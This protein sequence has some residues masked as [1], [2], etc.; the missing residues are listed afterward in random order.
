MLA[1]QGKKLSVVQNSTEATTPGE[2]VAHEATG[3][4]FPSRLKNAFL[5]KWE[6]IKNWFTPLG[7]AST[8]SYFLGAI[9]T[10]LVLSK[11]LSPLVAK[12]AMIPIVAPI[13]SLVL[14]IL[15][16]FE[17]AKLQTMLVDNAGVVGTTL[18]A[19]MLVLF[20]QNWVKSTIL[21][22]SMRGEHS[23][24]RANAVAG[25]LTPLFTACL[26]WQIIQVGYFELAFKSFGVGLVFIFAGPELAKVTTLNL[27]VLGTLAK[28]MRFPMAIIAGLHLWLV[29]VSYTWVYRFTEKLL[30]GIFSA[31]T[32]KQGWERVCDFANTYPRT[33]FFPPMMLITIFL[34]FF[35]SALWFIASFF[36]GLVFLASFQD[37][38]KVEGGG[39]EKKVEK[40]ESEK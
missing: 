28:T 15:G 39:S 9:F 16:E 38:E 5:R 32:W 33:T 3:D 7:G 4:T 8:L 12:F 18:G 13:A 31:T 11:Y 29:Y 1:E 35:V 26:W 23:T 24:Y 2:I 20:M 10:V 19:T 21:I 22:Q 30:G 17:A 34:G 36:V 40:E 27:E 6:S 14:L 37:S 25:L